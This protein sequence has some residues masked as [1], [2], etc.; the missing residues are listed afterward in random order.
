MRYN[1]EMDSS[2]D[3]HFQ[4]ILSA[5]RGQNYEAMIQAAQRALQV[6]P[7]EK[8]FQ[9][10]LHEAQAYYVNEK[11]HSD[12]VRRL[13]AK[14]DW[15]SL[16]AVYQK[17]LTVFPESRELHVLL[18]KVRQKLE[19]VAQLQNE[20]YRKDS[21]TQIRQ[22]IQMGHLDEAEQAC[23]ELLAQDL[24]NRSAQYLLAHVQHKIEREMD[25]AMEVF[26]KTHYGDL[27]LE[28]AKNKEAFVRA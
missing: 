27:K 25:Q 3:T 2:K 14:E 6:F 18:D 1:G 9:D 17:L 16:A 13:E 7:S 11:L 5:K 22:M 28:Y 8:R 4:A 21:E 15:V 23:Y 24:H 19:R 20:A 12:V 26:Y 10:L